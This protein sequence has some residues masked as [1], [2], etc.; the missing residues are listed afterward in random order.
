[1]GAA[2][3]VASM[4]GF[5]LEDMWL[6]TVALHLPVGQIL[7]LFGLGGM[8]V[9]WTMARVQGAPVLT[10]QA[11]VPALG[12]RALAEMTGRVGYVLA[13]ALSPLTTAS[14]ILQATPLVVTLGAAMV[15]GERVGWRR[16]MAI[17]VGFAGVLIVLRP[18]DAGFSAASLF[19]LVGMVGFAGRDLA[20]RAAPRGISNATLGVYGFVM[21]VVSGAGLLAFQP[22]GW[23][24]PA[25]QDWGRIGLAVLVG[26][27]AYQAL[28]AAMRM[29]EVGVIAPF[30]YTRLIFALILG[31]ALF[32]E[33]PDAM[34][35]AGAGLI[36]GSG[37]VTLWRSRRGG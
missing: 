20:T 11:L 17:G 19:A 10:A 2:L 13:I 24:P 35:L 34:M 28:S 12:W 7:I 16:W 5:A 32:G 9:F 23:V 36:V 1:M 4:A 22:G 14:A 37:L 31:M 6:K 18:W 30:R 26:V 8:A 21:L 29:G 25:P 33:R 27:G 3:M 15:F